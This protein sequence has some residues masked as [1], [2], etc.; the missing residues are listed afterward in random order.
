MPMATQVSAQH[1]MFMQHRARMWDLGEANLTP[2][3]CFLAV[4]AKYFKVWLKECERCLAGIHSR[5]GICLEH[6]EVRE[7]SRNLPHFTSL[8][9][10]RFVAI[11]H[12]ALIVWSWC[13]SGRISG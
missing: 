3:E 6:L 10:C 2:T 9:M 7:A 8:L 13:H 4:S 5:V 1:G 11:S 12:A